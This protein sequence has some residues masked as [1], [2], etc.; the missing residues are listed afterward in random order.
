MRGRPRKDINVYIEQLQAFYDNHKRAPKRREIS[1]ATQLCK[2]FGSWNNA[3]KA[4]DISILREQNPPSNEL[5]KSLKQYYEK[6]SYSPRAVDCRKENGL[7][8]TK[9]YYRFFR[10]NSW[11]DVLKAAGLPIYFEKFKPNGRNEI[12]ILIEV[13]LFIRMNR[14]KSYSR[15]NKL[16]I[17]QHANLPSSTAL[18]DKYGSWTNVLKQAGLQLNNIRHNKKTF[19]KSLRTLA[20]EGNVPS[21]KEFAKHLGVPA[22]SIT[23]HLGPF[24]DFVISQGFT[25]KFKTPKKAPVRLP[26]PTVKTIAHK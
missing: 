18:C 16:K 19:I 8:D 22:R 24:N 7:Y 17:M 14:I 1:N 26:R 21:L 23:M 10:L 15:Y 4:A 6:H 2:V 13:S 25:P 20:S 5:I 3:L 11:A 12:E 9:T